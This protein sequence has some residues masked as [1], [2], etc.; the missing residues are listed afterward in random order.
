MAE[1]KKDPIVVSGQGSDSKWS[2]QFFMILL[3][4]II[5]PIGTGYFLATQFSYRP[6][7]LDSAWGAHGFARTVYFYIYTGI[8]V[9]LAT[10]F[11]CFLLLAAERINKT[12]I[13]VYDS[14]I[15]GVGVIPFSNFYAA[16]LQTFDLKY[17]QIS[18][19]I[20]EPAVWVRRR[21]AINADGQVL[22]VYLPNAP[23]IA[24]EINSRLSCDSDKTL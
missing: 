2:V 7:G 14:H 11:V 16:R 22:H 8:G 18:A 12:R 13:N 21:I 15:E 5:L 17:N 20:D 19:V 24:S 1:D 9:V 4:A 3:A 6:V 10:G 23:D